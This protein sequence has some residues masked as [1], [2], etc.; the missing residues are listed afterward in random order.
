MS[1]LSAASMSVTDSLLV[2][3][4]SRGQTVRFRATSHSMQ[5]HIRPGALLLVR[6]ERLVEGDIVLARLGSVW[7]T[8]RVKRLDGARCVLV[9]DRGNVVQLVRRD[10]I[11]GRVI[12]VQHGFASWVWSLRW[13]IARQ[14][15]SPIRRSLLRW[16]HYFKRRLPNR[17]SGS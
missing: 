17:R 6:N 5:P 3:A 14:I 7:L 16:Y 9:G 11:F 15:P 12:A 13:N 10:Q 2:D 1:S 8:H 4:L